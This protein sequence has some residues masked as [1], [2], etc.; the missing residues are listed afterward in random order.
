MRGV[1]TNVQ[2]FSHDITYSARARMPI[3]ETRVTDI[4]ARDFAKPAKYPRTITIA[5]DSKDAKPLACKGSWLSIE[6]EE[7]RHA[8][9]L[10]IAR[11]VKSGKRDTIKALATVHIE[12]GVRVR[13]D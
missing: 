7:Y 1:R 9:V 8:F 4:M 3:L 10:V 6:A 12:H 13:G 5:V 2:L 11:D